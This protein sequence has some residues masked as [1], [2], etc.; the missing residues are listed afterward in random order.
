MKQASRQS[1]QSRRR[2]AKLLVALGGVFATC[3]LPYVVV[4][5]FAELAADGDAVEA[6]RELLPFVLLLG[7]THSAINPVVYWL[8]N[9]QTLRWPA[10]S[11]RCTSCPCFTGELPLR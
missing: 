10:I 6:V 11:A 3:W 2:L 9:R 1:L 5:V 4:R 7:H 8:L